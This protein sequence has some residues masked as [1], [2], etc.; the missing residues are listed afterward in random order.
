MKV[1]FNTTVEALKEIAPI[2]PAIKFIPEWFKKMPLQ[3]M[4]KLTNIGQGIG[5]SMS[6]TRNCPG[7]VEYFKQGYVVPLWSDLLIDIS[8][9]NNELKYAW[10]FADS[11]YQLTEHFHNQFLDYAPRYAQEKIHMIFKL[12][13][14]W[15]IKLPKGYFIYQLPM[16]YHYD[17]NFH[18]LPGIIPGDSYSEL[19]PQ[20]CITKEG[21]FI[22]ER[23][24]PIAHYVPVKRENFTLDVTYNN[25]E[26]NKFHTLSMKKVNSKFKK[27]WRNRDV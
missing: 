6:S 12:I 11:D 25:K 17:S 2:Q 7:I 26:M 4:E 9:K 8:R 22:I 23:G 18:V 15:T 1:R 5:A 19:N 27:R 3:Y 13:N 10:E 14:P 16:H 24:T 20:L 21:Q